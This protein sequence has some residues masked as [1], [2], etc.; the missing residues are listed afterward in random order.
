MRKA[1]ED[2]PSTLNAN[3]GSFLQDVFT[4]GSLGACEVVLK[5]GHRFF[6]TPVLAYPSYDNNMPQTEYL[7][8]LFLPVLETRSPRSK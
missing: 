7:I 4:E 1:A 6:L 3:S 2:L 8:N 5:H